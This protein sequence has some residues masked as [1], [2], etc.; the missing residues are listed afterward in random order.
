MC[1]VEVVRILPA[2]RSAVTA[3][4]TP[5]TVVRLEG[6]HEPGHVIESDGRTV[7][8]ARPSGRLLPLQYTFESTDTGFHYRRDADGRP[9]ITVETAV[10]LTAANGETEIRL[11]SSVDPAIPLPLLGWYAER[12]RRKRLERFCDRLTAALRR[13]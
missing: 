11:R 12:R 5:E 1:G 2:T 10:E 3:L 6:S 7:V 13:R 8:T 4:L 9:L